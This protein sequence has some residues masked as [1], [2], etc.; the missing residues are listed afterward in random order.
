[1]E[2]CLYARIVR[3]IRHG[4]K[5]L[6]V[7]RQHVGELKRAVGIDRLFVA[8]EQ[9]RSGCSCSSPKA[10]HISSSPGKPMCGAVG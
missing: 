7:A 10:F 3:R 8:E 9:G 2:T 1:M 4:D 6:I 5:E